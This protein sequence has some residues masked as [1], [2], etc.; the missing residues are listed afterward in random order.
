[1][2]APNYPYNEKERLISLKKYNLLDTY[3]EEDFDNLTSLISKICKVPI[4]LITLLDNNRNFFKSHFGIDFNESPR[5]TSFCGYA[6]LESQDIFIVE[7]THKD[8]RF[9]KNP[10]VEE[11]GIRFYAGKPLVNEEGFP[12][13]TLCIFDKKP[14]TLNEIEKETIVRISKQIVNLFELRRKNQMLRDAQE[15][16]KDKNTSLQIFASLVSHDLKSPL[17]NITSVSRLILEE[18]KE[19]LS[20]ES[21]TYFD[22]IEESAETLRE[23]INGILHYYKT[24]DYLHK[25]VEDVDLKE[26]FETFK[27]IHML[28]DSEFKY[29]KEGTLKNVSKSALTQIFL[30][31]IDNAIKYN[32]KEEKLIIIDVK[33]EN[34]SY[35]FSITDNSIGIANHK[36]DEIFQLFKTTGEKDKYGKEGTGI[37]LATVKNL[38]TKLG[39]KINLTSKLG[40]GSTFTFTIK[41]LL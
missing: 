29:P 35:V 39:G 33:E 2:I 28:R 5:D 3:P 37:G 36:K 6:I 14:R 1:M 25:D 23:Y 38:V 21:L 22:Y 20:K 10:L 17:A 26:F 31:L 16:L 15:E 32:K 41:K 13:G 4:C 24:D 19:K 9:I 40:E 12:L 34:N 8:L 30:N 18:N 7:D 11:D 27:E